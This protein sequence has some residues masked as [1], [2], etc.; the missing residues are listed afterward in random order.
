MADNIPELLKDP[1][2][3][4]KTIDE[5]H[6]YFVR[7]DPSISTIINVNCINLMHNPNP[8]S[9]NILINGLSRIGK[10]EIVK[11]TCKVICPLEKYIHRSKLSKEAFTYWHHNEEDWTWNKKTLHLED[12][13]TGIL[14]GSVFKTM[15]SGSNR[16]T[17]VINGKTIEFEVKG[18][19][20]II[21]TACQISPKIEIFGRFGILHMDE[22]PQQIE[23][24][25]RYKAEMREGKITIKPNTEMSAI[26]KQY[27]WKEVVEVVIPYSNHLYQLFPSKHLMTDIFDRFLDL[28]SASASFHRYQREKDSK[29]RIIADY[30]DY[31][32]ARIS[33]MKLQSTELMISPTTNEQRVIDYLKKESGA[34][35][36][37]IQDGTGL[38]QWFCT[39]YID[40][41]ERKGFL[42]SMMV[43]CERANRK[44]KKDSHLPL[45]P[46]GIKI[47]PL[48]KETITTITTNQNTKYV[49][50][51]DKLSGTNGIN[52][53]LLYCYLHNKSIEYRKQDKHI[54]TYIHQKLPNYHY[55]QNLIC[56]TGVNGRVVGANGFDETAI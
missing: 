13:E 35:K 45:Y 30:S 1:F 41:M 7:E 36:S 19:P 11:S 24:I 49:V 3:L 22:S 2:L 56:S 5:V 52:G 44:V 10:D 42:G 6:N 21:C 38:S 17:V 14:N 29:G 46:D 39:N 8:I 33:I 47:D 15:A 20:C 27:L 54:Y 31:L 4:T 32:I 51:L 23:A 26:F 55:Y 48:A 16:A 18:K 12:I 50:D 25:K 53:I 40:E 34:N 43:D 28:I 37:E 9:S